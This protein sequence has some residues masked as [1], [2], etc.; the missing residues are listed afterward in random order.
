MVLS[1]VERAAEAF[2]AANRT[3]NPELSARFRET[4]YR[5]VDLL[6]AQQE[7]ISARD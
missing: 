7:E 1:Y 6:R 5:Y 2:V 4:A 3:L